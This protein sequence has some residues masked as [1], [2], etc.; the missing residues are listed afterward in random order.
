MKAAVEETEEKMEKSKLAELDRLKWEMEEKLK[1]EK[2]RAKESA[3]TWAKSQVPWPSGTAAMSQ[4]Q[5]HRGR[6]P[7]R[8]TVPRH[9]VI[10]DGLCPPAV[11]RPGGHD[12]SGC[13]GEG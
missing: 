8:A 13:K 3:D 12:M 6:E 1:R 11:T 4:I 9:S 5:W 10:A 2:K 7:G